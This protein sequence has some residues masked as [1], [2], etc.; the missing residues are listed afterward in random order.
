[1][2]KVSTPKEFFNKILPNRFKPSQSEGVDIT[3]QINITDTNQS[4]VVI[5]KNRN[6][7]I[8]ENTH[9]KPN[10]ELIISEK[11]FLDIVNGKI[12]AEKAFFSGK[13]QL[14]GSIALALKLKEAGFF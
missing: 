7:T 14:K 5:I 1:M 12:S 6:I 13:A 4:W 2:E 8:E 11:N 3:V 9:P 10:L